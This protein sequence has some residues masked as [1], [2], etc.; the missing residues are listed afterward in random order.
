[1]IQMCT[2]IQKFKDFER[3]GTAEE[4]FKLRKAVEVDWH[5]SRSNKTY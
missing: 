3:I 2:V 1:M 5:A 4:K